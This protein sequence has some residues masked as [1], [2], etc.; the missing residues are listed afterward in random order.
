[1][2]FVYQRMTLIFG[3]VSIALGVALL[4]ETLSRGGGVGLLLGV[5]FIGLGA[6]RIYL[7]RA[8]R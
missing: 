7:L 6:G 1:M 3:V 4:V 2:R 8:R 5:L